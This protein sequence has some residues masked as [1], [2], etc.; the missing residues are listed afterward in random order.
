MARHLSLICV[1]VC[2]GA[3]ALAED[4]PLWVEGEQPLKKQRP[5]PI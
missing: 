1:L 2:L 4:A 3:A 5:R